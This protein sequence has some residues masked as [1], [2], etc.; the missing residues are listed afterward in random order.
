MPTPMN[1]IPRDDVGIIFTREVDQDSG[2]PYSS[3]YRPQ[4]FIKHAA[5]RYA[6]RAPGAS[7]FLNT[8][9]HKLCVEADNKRSDA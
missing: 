6:S 4:F 2:Q 5:N 3:S 9:K 1:V 8:P 7:F